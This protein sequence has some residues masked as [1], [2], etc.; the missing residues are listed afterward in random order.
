MV[1]QK[2]TRPSALAHQGP[3]HP[4]SPPQQ[5]KGRRRDPAPPLIEPPHPP[6]GTA[7]PL[8]HLAAVPFPTYPMSIWGYAASSSSH[9]RGSYHCSLPLSSNAPN[10]CAVLPCECGS[11]L[12]A[13]LPFVFCSIRALT[14]H[15][16]WRTREAHPANFGRVHWELR[17]DGRWRDGPRFGVDH[18]RHAVVGDV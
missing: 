10:G 6:T 5:G 9:L 15:S 8:I 4:P 3:S 2:T 18:I 17:I 11:G 13:R 1:F 16:A 7:L 12:N 14:P